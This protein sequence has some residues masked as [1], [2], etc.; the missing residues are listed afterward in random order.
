MKLNDFKDYKL[1]PESKAEY[2]GHVYPIKAVCFEECLFG[3][4]VDIDEGLFW[5]RCENIDLV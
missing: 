4:D 3:I 2:G 5:V 1:T